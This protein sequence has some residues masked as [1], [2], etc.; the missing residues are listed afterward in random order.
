MFIVIIA[1]LTPEDNSNQASPNLA[2]IFF[3]VQL[4]NQYGP[5]IPKT[6]ILTSI[7][8]L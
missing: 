8:R 5:G 2:I 3:T 6:P 4:S 1:H 7:Y